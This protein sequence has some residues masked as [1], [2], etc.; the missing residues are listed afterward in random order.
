MRSTEEVVETLREALTGVGVTLPSLCVDP[1]TG[2]SDEPFALVDLGRCNVRTAERLASVL[3]GERPAVG[4][5]ATDARDG[6]VGE[7]MG[8]VGGRVQ[9]RPVGGGRE[10]ECPPEA[11]GA[12]PP[13]DV[14]RA[15]VRSRNR[16]ARLT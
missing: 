11:V 2:A 10:W 4:A 15:R 6:R 12:A 3:R 7:V 1:V 16:E 5:Y 14:L 13:E 8:H 9:L